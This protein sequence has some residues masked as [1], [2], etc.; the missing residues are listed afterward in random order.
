MGLLVYLHACTYVLST[1][2]PTALDLVVV[3]TYP[4]VE[5]ISHMKESMAVFC[6]CW[7]SSV[8]YTLMDCYY[9]LMARV[10]RSARRVLYMLQ[11]KIECRVEI[12]CVVNNDQG[13]VKYDQEV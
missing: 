8:P 7:W 9:M 12:E 4:F 5:G 11:F 13:M 1:T 6:H 2:H 3:F 10:Q